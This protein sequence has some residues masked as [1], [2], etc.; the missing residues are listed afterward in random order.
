[1]LGAWLSALPNIIM[2]WPDV[3]Q[4]QADYYQAVHRSVQGKHVTIT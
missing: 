1:M 4:E 2:S 3:R